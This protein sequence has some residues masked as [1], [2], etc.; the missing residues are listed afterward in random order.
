MA[1]TMRSFSELDLVKLEKDTIVT[2]ESE[3]VVSDGCSERLVWHTDKGSIVMVKDYPRYFTFEKGR[4]MKVSA[5][6]LMYPFFY[7]RLIEY[8]LGVEWRKI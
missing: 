5:G 4:K 8:N 2:F 1:Y 7:H 3:E 6:F